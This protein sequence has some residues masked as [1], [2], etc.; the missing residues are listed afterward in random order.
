MLHPPG[1][2]SIRL[3][4]LNVYE[5]LAISFPTMVEAF[6]GRVTKAICDTRL[7]RWAS[8]IVE[9]AGI[10]L[11]VVGRERM[12]HGE[13][14]LVMSNHQSLYDIPVLFKVVGPNIRMI[15]KQE[16][17]RVPVFGAALVAGGF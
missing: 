9:N 17:F 11:D 1:P 8:N 6:Q 3:S 7:E 5:T 4:L 13:T 16:L 10:E 12:R 14:Y 2:A 15:T